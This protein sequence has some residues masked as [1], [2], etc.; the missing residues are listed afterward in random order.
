MP[1]KPKKRPSDVSEEYISKLRHEDPE[2]H[3]A[4]QEQY[5]KHVLLKAAKREKQMGKRGLPAD[6]KNISLKELEDYFL[7]KGGQKEQQQYFDQSMQLM[8]SALKN[9]KN[10]KIINDQ[11]QT[12]HDRPTKDLRAPVPR[13]TTHFVGHLADEE[14]WNATRQTRTRKGPKDP[15][16]FAEPPTHPSQL[17]DD[18]AS[19]E[20]ESDDEEVTMRPTSTTSSAYQ[21]DADPSEY[22]SSF[23]G[24]SDIS[25]SAIDKS[26][27]EPLL[28][29]ETPF[30]RNTP[31]KATPSSNVPSGTPMRRITPQKATPTP[32]P[33][34]RTRLPEWTGPVPARGHTP[35]GY[36]WIPITR[37]TRSSVPTPPPQMANDSDL[38]STFSGTPSS[39]S[40]HSVQDVMASGG[41]G[42]DSRIDRTLSVS[43]IRRL[44][45]SMLEDIEPP[46]DS[47]LDAT[48]GG[49]DSPPHPDAGFAAAHERH[50][51][52]RAAAEARYVQ[53]LG[54]NPFSTSG[55]SSYG[56]AGPSQG[57]GDGGG[58]GDDQ[59]FGDGGG[60]YGGVGADAGR[61]ALTD[62]GPAPGQP[63][64][65]PFP[66][67]K[68]GGG[69]GEGKLG[70]QRML[71]TDGLPVGDEEQ[72]I[73][74]VLRE[75]RQNAA[76]YGRGLE[77][78][79]DA[80]EI[81]SM[82]ALADRSTDP[83]AFAYRN[84]KLNNIQSLMNV[85]NRGGQK[86]HGTD[87]ERAN[88]Q[89]GQY[90]TYKGPYNYPTLDDTTM[91]WLAGYKH[92]NGNASQVW[93]S[94]MNSDGKIGVKKKYWK[95]SQK[96]QLWQAMR[97]RK[98]VD[99]FMTRANRK[100]GIWNPIRIQRGTTF[101]NYTRNIH[102]MLASA[103]TGGAGSGS[104]GESMLGN[105]MA[106]GMGSR[107]AAYLQGNGYASGAFQP[108]P[109]RQSGGYGGGG[110]RGGGESS[111][112]NRMQEW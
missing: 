70:G 8:K 12:F 50:E 38:S 74:H 18:P 106:A 2:Y 90:S 64:R 80:G 82:G 26:E 63:R 78:Y 47:F 65:R 75:E 102:R 53:E 46:E 7:K 29:P 68:R 92:V 77:P 24:P 105:M 94:L 6:F 108:P 56:A 22:N 66:D 40:L 61:G 85:S 62:W 25:S 101:G 73:G 81:M 109:I 48:F 69:Q 97:N 10:K 98:D 54:Y 89:Q 44:P 11:Q 45:T 20:E 58:G 4:L 110:G 23:S 103:M 72:G 42:G 5:Y 71:G 3:R 14:E 30:R 16:S 21:I 86:V 100:P 19:S 1:P 99:R 96:K 87:E 55:P 9:P 49:G 43:P 36:S 31:Q 27:L 51:Q 13:N 39:S 41:G 59:G 112:G 111:G 91:K 79:R 15:A 107:G 17:N 76:M 104:R 84:R 93:E 57:F 52:G 33:P 60:A 35:P 88:V 34:T 28:P 37:P 95:F 32:V 83:D 67:Q